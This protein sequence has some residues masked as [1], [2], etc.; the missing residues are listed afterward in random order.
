MTYP[1]VRPYFGGGSAGRLT[2]SGAY[3]VDAAGAIVIRKSITAFTAPKRFATG[4]GDDAR[5]Y[6]D[7]AASKG[8]NEVRCFAWSD[9]P[10]PPGAGVE[11]GWP[12]DQD[13]CAQTFVEAAKRGLRVQLVANIGPFGNGADDMAARLQAVDE[14]CLQ[15]ENAILQCG[16]EPHQNGG[17]ALMEAVL[18]RYTPRTPG[19]STGCYDPTVYTSIVQTGTD[20]EGRPVYTA[21]HTARVGQSADYHSPRKDEWSRCTKD[22]YECSTGAG[23]NVQFSPG[24]L[25]PVMLC[26]PPQIEATIREQGSADWDPVDDWEAYGA[27]CAFWGG[28]GTA[29]GNP[30]FQ[31]CHIPSDPNVVACLEAFYRGFSRVPVQRYHGY[32][33]ALQPTPSTNPGSRRY[34]RSGEDGRTYQICVRPFSFGVV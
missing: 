5:R 13:A 21:S 1:Q 29:H 9:W 4:R 16:N 28:G 23:P 14:L 25:G 8:S 30:D 24:Y 3:F 22:V 12:Y 15:H 26:E 11:S 6:F 18:E 32:S 34:R 33:G 17:H 27:G 20:A 31:Q 7:W 2:V 10:G 19:W